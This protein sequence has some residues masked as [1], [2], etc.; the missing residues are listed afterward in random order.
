MSRNRW[1]G[2]QDREILRLAVP[3]FVALVSEPLMLLADSAIVGH[4]GTP[5]LAALGIA[6]T[7]L[8]TLVGL[9]IFLAYGTTS[10][11]ARRIGAGDHRGALAQGIDG[12]WLALLLGVVLAV[13]GV[14]FAPQAIGVF[15][16]S[17]DVA[18]HALTYLRISYIGIPSMVL[19]LAAT[20]VLRGL[21]D[22]KTPM[23]V[24]ISANL[25]NIVLN[26][27]LVYGLNLGIAGSALGTVIAQTGA[28]VALVVVVVRGARRDG[29]KLKPDLPGILASAQMGLPLVVRTLTLRAAILLLTYVVTGLGTTSLAAHQV[30][31]TLWNFLTLALDAIAIAA[32]ALTG[33]ALGAGDVASTR[34]ITRRMMWWG[35]WSGVVCGLMLWGLHSVYVPWFTTDPEVR[36]TLSAIIVV[37][38][39]W[40]PLNGVVFVLDGVLIGAGDGRYLA[41]AGVIALVLYVPLALSVLWFDGSVVALWW[42]FNGFMLLRLITLVTRERRD[43]WLVTGAT[44]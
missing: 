18:E 5:Q 36:H 8:Q 13:A 27:L 3:A 43:A 14:V 19:L 30:A 2:N 21:Q 20:G 31:F 17:P 11:V 10:A 7:V 25:A 32:Q 35:L 29:A 6:G 44:R 37:A 4:L 41:I 26:L 33:R 9:C 39:I 24:A 34:S 23:V 28:G 15:N 12:L 42:A 16:P 40:Q 1:V 38:A 22:T